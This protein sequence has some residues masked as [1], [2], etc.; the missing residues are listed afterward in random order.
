Q[1]F[2]GQATVQV[3]TEG[4]SYLPV[5]NLLSRPELPVVIPVAVVG[6]LVACGVAV[7]W[8]YL[9]SR[10]KPEGASREMVQALLYQKQ[11]HESHVYP[12]G[13]V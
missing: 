9:K 6:G 7:V 10:V 5:P 1:A 8:H 4:P 11:G 3:T 2:S 12:V 13:V